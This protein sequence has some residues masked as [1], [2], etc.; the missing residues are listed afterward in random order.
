MPRA[1]PEISVPSLDTLALPDRTL[2]DLT[3][4]VVTPLFGGGPTTRVADATAP[5][6]GGT[7][8]GHLRFWWRAC[9]AHRF[10]RPEDLFAAEEAIWGSAR[11]EAHRKS[12]PGAIEVGIEIRNPGEPR[13]CGVWERRMTWTDNWPGYALFP[14]Q[15]KA[16]DPS[17]PPAKALVDVAFRLTLSRAPHIPGEQMDELRRA[18]EAAVWAWVTFGGVGARTRRGCGA[19][20]CD[21]PRFHPNGGNIR[22]W[23]EA[24]ARTHLAE[25]VDGGTR[26][27]VPTL[28]GAWI[29]LRSTQDASPVAAWSEAVDVYRRFR[30][31]KAGGP[32]GKS[33][34]PD[35]D[36]VRELHRSGGRPISFPRAELGLPIVFQFQDRGARRRGDPPQATLEVDQDGARR[37]ASPIIVK[38]LMVARQEAV[39][40]AVRLNAPLLTDLGVPLRLQGE[41]TA[42][43]E[44]PAHLTPP[45]GQGQEP[46]LFGAANARN[47]FL[48]HLQ[49]QRSWEPP[50]E[51]G[52]RRGRS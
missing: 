32:Y 23:L 8:R 36:A 45:P 48:R 16:N 24:R 3:I 51:I 43:V 7:V 38:P 15:G 18:A 39:A 20:Y 27:A 17:D 35:A 52:M 37:M 34:W 5:V 25:P 13:V 2:L 40:L 21:D 14:F 1:L 12:G 28:H 22:A 30:Q 44:N 41:V 11:V 29:S 31:Q 4:H 49:R 26:L 19:L 50:F 46:P 9:N 6:R 10:S 47:G 33:I 42:P